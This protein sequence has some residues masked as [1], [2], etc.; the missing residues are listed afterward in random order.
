MESYTLESLKEII[1]TSPA[2]MVYFYNDNCAPCMVL[3][4]KMK[5]LMDSEFP[6]IRQEYINAAEQPEIS[7][8]YGIFSAPVVL[9]FFDGQEVSRD[10]KFVSINEFNSKIG[11]Y[12][13]MY[14][15]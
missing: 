1:R 15:E 13:S 12:Y 14:F 4:P 11:R 2:L 6:L 10:S 5:E 9:V 8:A 7:S 3:R